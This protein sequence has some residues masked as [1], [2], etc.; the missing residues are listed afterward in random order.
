[1]NKDDYS[2]CKLIPVYG[3]WEAFWDRGLLSFRLYDENG[4]LVEVRRGK[5]YVRLL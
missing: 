1:M 5:W 4:K 2:W 3:R